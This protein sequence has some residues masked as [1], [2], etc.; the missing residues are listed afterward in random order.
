MARW[1]L[2]R[3]QRGKGFTGSARKGITQ[4]KRILRSLAKTGTLLLLVT[5]LGERGLAGQPIQCEGSRSRIQTALGAKMPWR[6]WPDG[7]REARKTGRPMLVFVGGGGE[8]WKCMWSWHYETTT[9]ANPR[10]V[11]LATEEMVP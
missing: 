7:L 6:E 3:L 2:S 11:K 9:F 4:M 5:T 8:N 10:I 1:L